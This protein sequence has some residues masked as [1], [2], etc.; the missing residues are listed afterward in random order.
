MI[1]TNLRSM[2]KQDTPGDRLKFGL[3][4]MATHL[5]GRYRI[6]N[7]RSSMVIESTH[8]RSTLFAWAQALREGRTFDLS[9]EGEGLQ[10]QNCELVQ[11][12]DVAQLLSDASASVALPARRE[13]ANLNRDLAGQ[14]VI[15]RT[16][17]EIAQAQWSRPGKATAHIEQRALYPIRI[18]GRNRTATIL[19]RLLRASGCEVHF[20]D[21]HERPA[22][23]DLDLGIAHFQMRDLGGNFYQSLEEQTPAL[24]GHNSYNPGALSQIPVVA[25]PVLHIHCGDIDIDDLLDWMNSRTPHLVVFPPVA[26]EVAISPITIAGST[27]CLRCMHLFELDSYG[28]SRQ[29]RISLTELSDSPMVLAHF[30]AANVASLA[31]GFVDRSA[32]E[33]VFESAQ[34]VGEITYIDCADIRKPQVVAV[35]RHPLCG[36]SY[37][38]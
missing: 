3:S 22:I 20:A 4:L 35:D 37:F 11:A 12:M 9:R 38:Q 21:R 8:Q 5:Q 14:Q 17:P 26:G 7:R 16:E 36:C 13:G 23:G 25:T 24:F 19:Y 15:A 29:E 32:A 28:F 27:P 31:I 6:G 2:R 34:G 18:S 33:E 10:S 1:A 30:V